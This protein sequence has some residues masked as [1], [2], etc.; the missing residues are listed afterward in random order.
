VALLRDQNGVR[1][2]DKQGKRRG[3][4]KGGVIAKDTAG[5]ASDSRREIAK[6]TAGCASDSRRE[7]WGGWHHSDRPAR[8]ENSRQVLRGVALFEVGFAVLFPAVV[9]LEFL[10][11][12]IRT[13]RKRAKEALQN[14]SIW[15][16][17][18]C[19]C[20]VSYTS[21]LIHKLASAKF[22]GLCFGSVVH[23]P[24]L[25]GIAYLLGNNRAPFNLTPSVV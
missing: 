1:G 21:R 18:A 14:L 9:S 20:F 22:A 25:D 16:H 6:D 12:S 13:F 4:K 7:M 17:L 11:V 10:A 23:M 15:V 24:V 19:F 2:G 8:Q 3:E 5:C